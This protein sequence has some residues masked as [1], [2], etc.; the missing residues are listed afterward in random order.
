[1][2]D[3]ALSIEGVVMFAGVYHISINL[4]TIKPYKKPSKNVQKCLKM[5]GKISKRYGKSGK[6]FEFRNVLY[7]V[8]YTIDIRDIPIYPANFQ[9]F[10]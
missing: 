3:G 9:G 1:M 8:F 2:E 4:S 5:C 7:R 6:I 10:F